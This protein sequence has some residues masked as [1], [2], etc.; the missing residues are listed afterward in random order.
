MGWFDGYIC[1]VFL[2]VFFS[3]FE[4][5]WRE[6]KFEPFKVIFISLLFSL[7]FLYFVLLGGHR[8]GM[9]FMSGVFMYVSFLSRLQFCMDGFVWS[10]NSWISPFIFVIMMENQVSLALSLFPFLYFSLIL[11][12]TPS[13]SE[14]RGCAVGL[15]CLFSFWGF[16][17]SYFS[18][19]LFPN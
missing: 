17:Y 12:L 1:F 19:Y 15:L 11:S 4:K 16:P 5:F 7:C 6:V 9:F 14:L 13:L 10:D 3:V 2:A 8:E 18:F